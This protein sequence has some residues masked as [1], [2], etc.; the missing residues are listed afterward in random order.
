M[1]VGAGGSIVLS[2]SLDARLGKEG[3]STHFLVEVT[4]VD[5]GN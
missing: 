4:I 3:N 2:L 5:I 1:G